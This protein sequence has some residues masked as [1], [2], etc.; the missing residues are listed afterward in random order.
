MAVL[1]FFGDI[2]KTA[3]VQEV[4]ARFSHYLKI[5]EKE[6]IIVTSHGKPHAILRGFSKADLED[7][8]LENNPAIRNQVEEVYK[9]Y[10]AEG[11]PSLDE[12]I[13]KLE[14]KVAKK[15]RR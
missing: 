7:Y 15:V 4:K 2:M 11:G 5:S 9:D 13:K 6:D 1:N 10:L 12:V 8:I 14:K 3:S